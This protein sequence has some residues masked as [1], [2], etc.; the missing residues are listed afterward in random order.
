MAREGTGPF[1]NFRLTARKRG[2]RGRPPR[3]LEWAGTL[4]PAVVEL[5][6]A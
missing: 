4:A 1:S 6:E 5:P 3:H 2:P